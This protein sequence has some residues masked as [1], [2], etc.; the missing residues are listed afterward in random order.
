MRKGGTDVDSRKE[1]ELLLKRFRH[2]LK[3]DVIRLYDEVDPRTGKYK[4]DIK[5]LDR[6]CSE[7]KE[8]KGFTVDIT[9]PI[10][11][12]DKFDG[13]VHRVTAIYFPLGSPSG[14]DITI[15]AG[16]GTD[17]WRSIDEVVL[18]TTQTGQT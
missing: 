5:E 18:A 8:Y 9:Q 6:R 1:Y 12:T 7:C 11:A 2:L 14:K 4:R 15:D 13:S 10:F 17:E 3:S 16:D